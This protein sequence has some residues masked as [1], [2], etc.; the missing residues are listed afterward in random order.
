MEAADELMLIGEA[1]E[2]EEWFNRLDSLP[3]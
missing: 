2:V 3:L 1:S